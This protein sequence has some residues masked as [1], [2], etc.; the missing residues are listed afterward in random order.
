MTCSLDRQQ[1]EPGDKPASADE[2]TGHQLT[3]PKTIQA[4]D[5]E[6]KAHKDFDRPFASSH[7]REKKV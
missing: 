1:A 3:T 2:K 4:K 6:G 7:Q 5:L